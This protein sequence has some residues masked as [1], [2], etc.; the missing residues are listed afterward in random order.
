MMKTILSS[1]PLGNLSLFRLVSASS[2]A[3]RL[4]YVLLVGTVCMCSLQK[5]SA[6]IIINVTGTS[7]G[8]GTITGAGPFSATTLRGAV[9]HA[10]S[11]AGSTLVIINIPNGT[12]QLNIVGTG[13]GFSGPTYTFNN[14]IGDLD[15]T[16]SNVSI[17]GASAASTIIQQTT[18]IDRVLETNPNLASGWIFDLQNV[19]IKGGRETTGVGGGGILVGGPTS[20]TTVTNCIFMNN[21]ATGAGGGGGGIA[22]GDGSMTVNGCTFGG[23][24]VN[25][26]NTSIR[27]GGI[28][29]TSITAATSASI[30]N[31]NFISNSA[32]SNRGGGIYIDG[33]NVTSMSILRNNFVSNTSNDAAGGGGGAISNS[34]SPNPFNVNYNRFLNNTAT[35]QP[36]NGNTINNTSGTNTLN[37][38][39]NWWGVNTEP[40]T[41]STG[42]AGTITKTTWLQLRHTP[43]VTSLCSNSA[44]TLTADILGRNSGGSTAATNLVGL[45]NFPLP[46][47]TIC[48][49]AT[50]GSLSSAATQFVNGIATATFTAGNTAGAGGANATLDNQVINAAITVNALPNATITA[51]STACVNTTFNLSVVF[52]GVGATYNWSGNGIVAVNAN[53]TTATPTVLNSQAYAV[54]VTNSNNCTANS[55]VN[56][57]VNAKPTV[58]ITGATSICIGS[59]TTLSPNAGGTWASSNN[60]LATVTN[61]GVVTG[62]STGSPTFN[63]TQTSTGCTS[64]P[65]SSVTINAD[66]TPGAT[67]QTVTQDV[68]TSTYFF[69]N[70]SSCGTIITRIVP[71]TPT[72]VSGSVTA[73]SL[74]ETG[75]IITS[76]VPNLSVARHYELT[77][78]VAA[79]SATITLYF[80]QAEFNAFN[81]SPTST[82]DLPT[83]AGDA[84]GIGNLRVFK[85]AG[86]GT[87]SKLPNN[88][89]GALT[90]ID[91]VDANIVFNSAAS[92][93]EVTFT[94]TGFSGFFLGTTSSAVLSVDL[95]S[96]KATPSVLGNN[97]T[98]ITANEINNK[99]FQVER[100]KLIGN[101]WETLGFVKGNGLASTYNFIDK[102]PYNVSYYRL[103]QI[104]DDGKETISNVVS[105]NRDKAKEKLKVYPNPVSNVLIVETDNVSDYQVINLLGQ[106]VMRGKATQQIDVSALV[107]GAYLLRIGTEQVSFVKQ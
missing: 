32:S 31:S 27:G 4:I 86:T 61:A 68:S 16:R 102:T 77:P 78:P 21:Q 95:L 30:S 42:G 63:F 65:T 53:A 25:E 24:G 75:V 81:S 19:T 55:S 64:L 98:W 62:V 90:T 73:Q 54:T 14:A 48:S 56:V 37:A 38:N 88:Y 7:D 105:V 43:S 94:T 66:A 3:Y 47:T 67:G 22:L 9:A 2:I 45:P 59:T 57:T 84:T 8:A 5:A 82:V 71:T 35:N 87:G 107:Q 92:R 23:T 40:P 39:D 89:A 26:G 17:R 97:L 80:T 15:V 28:W 85:F 69:G 83:G 60:A 76:I 96:F 33:N 13:E 11:Q 51:P 100:K 79:S 103:K 29:I 34:A 18:T 101:S 58:S 72:P 20:T 44:T 1:F 6:Q 41:N 12:Y 50:L 104:D 93:W 10:N 74:I 49:G 99:G 52:A 91:P 70:N 106:Q 36:T 46:A